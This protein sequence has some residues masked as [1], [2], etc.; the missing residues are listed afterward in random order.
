MGVRAMTVELQAMAMHPHLVFGG[1]CLAPE[2]E[3]VPRP[4]ALVTQEEPV[5]ELPSAVRGAAEVELHV[6]SLARADLEALEASL[7]EVA[8]V[9]GFGGGMVMDTAKFIAW[10]RGI[11]LIL[12]PSIVS[13]DA[14]V[15]NTIAVRDDTR[16]LYEGFVVADRIIV[17][18]DLI[19]RAPAPFNRAGV[20]DLLSI[21]TALWDW[22][23]GAD[24]GRSVVVPNVAA[25]AAEILDEIDQLAAEI[26]EV[27]PR[28]IEAIVRAYVEV[29][30]LCL[31]V[32]HSQPEEG[33]EHYF[34][35]RLEAVTGRSFVHG[36]L[37]GLGTV[38]MAELQ[39]NNPARPKGILER[40][41]VAWHPER[42]GVTRQSITATLSGI[43]GFVRKGG[44]PYSILDEAPLHPAKVEELLKSLG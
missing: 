17:D 6:H 34:G 9:V 2:L 29:N 30:A 5:R 31:T 44:Y 39:G 25:R 33:S 24:R 18:T 22:H 36:Q 14:S 11:P 10:R 8:A 35:Y 38:L 32:G 4:F 3:T 23:L 42:L 19:R 7:P 27:T 16:V 21:H 41:R 37:I 1:G 20:G 13:V 43:S 12:A 15:T 26:G 40:C 28:A